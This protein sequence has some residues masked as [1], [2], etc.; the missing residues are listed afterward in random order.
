METYDPQRDGAHAVTYGQ[1]PGISAWA[2]MSLLMWDLGYPD[3]AIANGEKAL[4]LAR[5][6]GHPFTL[7]MAIGFVSWLQ[8]RLHNV[9]A[10]QELTDEAI[11][12]CMEQEFSLWLAHGQFNQGW[13]VAKRG[14]PQAGLEQMQAAFEASAATGSRATDSWR[15]LTMAEAYSPA[16]NIPYSLNLIDQAID[17]VET[18]EDKV[19]V[20][21]AYRLKGE[22][23]LQ[24][25]QGAEEAESCFQ[26]ALEAAR[27]RETKS[28]ELRAAMS[29]GRLWQSQGKTHE[30]RLLVEEV[31]T[32]FTEGFETKDLQD[33]RALIQA[34]GGQAHVASSQARPDSITSVPSPIPEPPQ[35]QP[36]PI[37]TATTDA[38][39]EDRFVFQR[40]GEYWTL[41]FQ[42]KMSRVKETRG[43]QYLSQLLDH[44]GQEF[45]ALDLASGNAQ[46]MQTTEHTAVGSAEVEHASV[47]AI[48]DAGEMLDPQ[49]QAAYRQRLKDLQS[50]LEE[51]QAFN[52]GGRI[53]HLQTE[54]DFL[55]RELSQAVGLGGRARKAASSSERAR[56]NVTRA[57]RTTIKRIT[58]GHPSLGAYLEQT[59]KTGTFC[60]Y[61]PDPSLLRR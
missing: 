11:A 41:V 31:Y 21:E 59:I 35:A 38:S 30:A 16:G 54:L 23:L 55:T 36:A 27:Q 15:Y 61:T 46:P 44:P 29:L 25:Q 2:Y 45:H 40:E 7:S 3:Q 5:T 6:L 8:Q 51:A 26:N 9:Q 42:G 32:W 1:D 33:A 39:S 60:C 57:I 20:A 24:A 56:V 49:A 4:Q 22:L 10:V 53:D 14:Q 34:L 52:D 47:D 43:V 58:E 50:E 19:Y 28:W 37:P 12:L 18:T 13:I 48:G 17:E